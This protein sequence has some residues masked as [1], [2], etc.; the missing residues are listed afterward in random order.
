MLIRLFTLFC[1][2]AS[3]TAFSADEVEFDRPGIGF[4]S[5]VLPAGKMTW[6]QGL[7]SFSHDADSRSFSADSLLR[8]GLG[9][10]F[11][12]Q[13]GSVLWQR[14]SLREDGRKQRWQGAG[15]SHISLKYAS[16]NNSDA[17]GWGVMLTRSQPTGR[18][19]LASA[20]A[21]HELGLSVTHAF[22]DT[23]SLALFASINR[24]QQEN[25]WLLSPSYSHALS[26][27]TAVYVEGGIGHGQ[28][29]MRAIGAGVT[30]MASPRVQLDASILRGLD[31]RTE[32]W[33][34]G[35]GI[36]IALN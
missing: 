35:L 24:D 31:R 23:Q 14:L 19:P 22:S 27:R 11:E 16:P 1:L 13:L 21:S 8:I 12:V 5:Q 17:F 4:G 20:S 10:G 15:D 9:R 36:A 32:D 34:G 18:A 28:Q 2:F 29:H 26:S 25:G 33:Q 6:E 7:P 30:W 3:A